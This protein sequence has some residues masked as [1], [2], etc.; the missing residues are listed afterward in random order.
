MT[1]KRA[2]TNNDYQV[3]INHVYNLYKD[4][5]VNIVTNWRGGAPPAIHLNNLMGDHST[6]SLMK[7]QTYIGQHKSQQ[8]SECSM[9][10]DNWDPDY[11]VTIFIDDIYDTG[12][13]S[14]ECISYLEFNCVDE[15]TV[16]EHYIVSRDIAKDAAF[17]ETD[18]AWLIFPWEL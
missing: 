15:G 18:G 11:D 13:S 14:K 3:F 9:V 10:I 5:T 7:Y 8:K 4:Y 16:K 1:Q 12:E 6:L 2:V 17:Y